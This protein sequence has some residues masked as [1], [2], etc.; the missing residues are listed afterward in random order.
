VRH[1]HQHR[2]TSPWPRGNHQLKALHRQHKYTWE[3]IG[4]RMHLS[5]STVKMQGKRLG[6]DNSDITNATRTEALQRPAPPA[7]PMT[8]LRDNKGMLPRGIPTLPPLP[9]LL[10]PMPQVMQ[11]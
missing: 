7:L 11:W 10:M 4:K 5:T 8:A 3:Q 6:L 2:A 9:S 1:M